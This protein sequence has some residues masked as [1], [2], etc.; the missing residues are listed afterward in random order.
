M[1]AS[2]LTRAVVRPL[3]Q[4]K[5]I[6]RVSKTGIWSAVLYSAAWYAEKLGY[7]F[8]TLLQY[9]RLLFVNFSVFLL[10]CGDVL[11][12]FHCTAAGTNFLRIHA[13]GNYSCV[14]SREFAFSLDTV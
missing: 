11:P 6:F 12:V 13:Y 10:A 14:V 8:L 7:T 3:V 4:K 2:Y 9:P 1:A 5:L